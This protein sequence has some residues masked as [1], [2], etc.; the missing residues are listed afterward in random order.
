M[1]TTPRIAP[2]RR[3]LVV[4]AA[5]DRAFQ[6]FVDHFDLWWPRGHHLGGAELDRCV[7]EPRDGGR[8]YEVCVDG[9]ECDWGRVLAWEPPGRLLLSWQIDGSF[10]FEPD[11]ARASE[12]EITFEALDATSTKVAL[13]HRHLERMAGAEGGRAA[14]DGEGGWTAILRGYAAAVDAA[15][16]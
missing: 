1:T 8:W 5:V 2:V 4:P 10:R 12:V 14:I 13:E 9:S 6:V 11:P 15:A 7:L 16:R 3:E